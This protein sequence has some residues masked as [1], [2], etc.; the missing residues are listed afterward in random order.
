MLKFKNSTTATKTPYAL[1]AKQVHGTFS[2]CF[3]S[4]LNYCRNLNF[5]SFIGR[6]LH[7]KTISE[8]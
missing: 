1:H 4:S 5:L 2:L 7:K 6:L 8:I 3:N